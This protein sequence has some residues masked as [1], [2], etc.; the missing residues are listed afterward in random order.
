MNWNQYG[1]DGYGLAPQGAIGNLFGQIA[2]A[3]GG[4][5]GGAF[6]QPQLGGMLG[7]IAGQLGSSML[8]FSAGPQFVPQGAMGNLFGQIAPALGGVVG[9][10]FGQ[11]QLGG[12]LGNVAG[13]LGSM[14]P[15]SAGPQLVPQ[16]A[17]GNLFGQ[18][19][20]VLG[21]VAGTAL[22]QPMLGGMLGNV[23]GQLGS[24][25]LPFSAGPHFVPQGAIGNLFGQIAPQLG[26]TLGGMWGQ[27]QVG[28][29]LGTAAG[30]LG[31]M[32]PFSA[33][34]TYPGPYQRSAV[35]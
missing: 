3:L 4:A 31:S 11:P 19:A 2:P 33:A 1:G 18:I 22:G 25:V 9:G 14:L 6:G 8:P 13:Q 32:L 20:P 29:M 24:S 35:N 23:L 28:S 5:L 15:F 26:G 17:I 10:A 30:Q 21:G 34:P 7:N 16:G 12:M 27:P